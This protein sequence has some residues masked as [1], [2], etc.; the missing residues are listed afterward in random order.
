MSEKE[1][2]SSLN[3]YIEYSK[4]DN[5]VKQVVNV[6]TSMY[7]NGNLSMYK[8]GNENAHLF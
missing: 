4:T 1:L 2:D 8:N 5:Y 3:E 7:K 6:N